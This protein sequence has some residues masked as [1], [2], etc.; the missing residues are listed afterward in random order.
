[1]LEGSETLIEAG[2]AAEANTRALRRLTLWILAG[3]ACT[4]V[5]VVVL[6]AAAIQ[7]VGMIDTS[8]AAHETLQVK[9]AVLSA[10]APFDDG[11]LAALAR[12]L[13]LDGARL[14]TASEVAADE[15]S[16]PVSGEQVVAFTPHRFGLRTFET[17]APLRIVVGVAF[18][19]MVAFIGFR[20]HAVSRRLDRRRAAATRLALTDGLTGL[21]NRMA[22]DQAL[23]TR[24]EAAA[25]GGPGVV[26]L[27][28]DLDGFKGIND[29]L[30]HAAGDIVLQ[31]V[32]RHLR[33]TAHPDDLVA[34]IGG[35]EFAVLCDGAALDDFI[36]SLR[37]R[38]ATPIAIDARLVRI[39]ASIGVAR[40]EDFPASP[41][42]L[43]QAADA[44]LY[45]AKRSGGGIAELAVPTLPPRRYAA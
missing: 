40:S 17:V 20:V 34:R 19:L 5:I 42:K 16:V 15:R 1:V 37:A 36:G 32:A 28:A 3:L 33:E 6:I 26:L 13:D 24:F 21:G 18:V 9:R 22:F 35:D 12:N 8:S 27:L 31:A 2:A 11:V 4:I 10:P 14:T 44:A 38:L 30:G 25:G 45:R 41:S 43:T 39:G 7:A 23:A 29:E